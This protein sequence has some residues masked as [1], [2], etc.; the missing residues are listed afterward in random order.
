MGLV[1]LDV[2]HKAH[3]AGIVFIRR[4]VETGGLEMFFFGCR[5]HGALLRVFTQIEECSAQQHPCQEE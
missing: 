3:T 5:G 4:V 1:T 2:G